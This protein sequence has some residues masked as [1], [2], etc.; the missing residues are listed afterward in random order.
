MAPMIRKSSFKR[1]RHLIRKFRGRKTP[2]AVKSLRRRLGREA[3]NTFVHLWRNAVAVSGRA[4]KFSIERPDLLLFQMGKVGSS[5]LATAAL[6]HGINC[7]H[8]HSLAYNAEAARL[9]RLFHS[10]PNQVLS[11]LDLRFLTK[12]TTLNMLTRWYKTNAAS[13]GR[14]VKVISLTR[15]PA[16]RHVSHLLQRFDFRSLA[17]W[18]RTV[19]NLDVMTEQDLTKAVMELWRQLA[20]LVLESKPS[21]DLPRAHAHGTAAIASMS[22]PQPYLAKHFA[23]TIGPLGWFDEQFRPVFDLDIRDM[24]ELAKNGIAQRELSF[25]DILIVRYEDLTRHLGAMADFLC[26]SSLELPP[27]NV[28]EKKAHAQDILAAAR[29]FNATDLG[30]AFA[31]ELR[32]SDYGRACGYD[33]LSSLA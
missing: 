29:T 10:E 25:A 8:C 22:P 33:K 12:H 17:D 30:R 18:Y 1:F 13:A 2:A 21:V 15:D 31:R 23:Q 19:A 14:K 11:A 32:E 28:T 9:S 3:S 7:F 24:P 4:E 6:D 26:I 16:T 27:V 20:Q 5:A